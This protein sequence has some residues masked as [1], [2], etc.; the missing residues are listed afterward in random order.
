VLADSLGAVVVLLFAQASIRFYLHTHRLI[1]AVFFVQQ[2]WVAGSFLTRRRPGA[3]SHRPLEWAV[4]FGGSFGGY[5]LRPAGLHPA[6]GVKAGLV[7]QLLGLAVW[8][9]A[10]FALGRSFGL[11]PADRR[12]VGSGPYSIIRHPLYASYMVT[13]LGY[14]LQSVS[15]WNG[16]VL[17]STFSCQVAR[18][19][20]EERLLLTTG[21]YAEYRKRVR[22][23]LIPLVW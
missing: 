2:L 4:A 17:V 21:P 23:R 14:L 13:Q 12:L 7:L 11:V 15:V 6:W 3:V 20:A 22:W 9:I 10:F 19:L 18:A 1:G 8:A 16:A 5:L